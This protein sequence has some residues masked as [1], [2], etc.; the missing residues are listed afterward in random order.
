MF[1]L[2]TLALAVVTALAT[3][4]S[5]VFV[6]LRK[7]SMLVDGIG[8]AVFPGIVIG[9]LITRDLNSPLLLLGAALA[10]M[11]VVVGADWLRSTRMIS[12]DAP[13]GLIFP[14]LFAVG[15]IVV[16]SSLT[17]VHLDTHVV[18]VGDLNLASFDRLV[19]GG[20]D[21]G[22]SYLY[23][24]LTMLI[25]NAVFLAAALPRLTVSTFD[26]EFAHLIGVRTK[27]LGLVNM[28]LV[29]VTATA[30][31]HA[32]GA[33]LIIALMITPAATAHLVSKRV[34]HMIAWTLVFAGVGAIAGFL[35]AYGV[36]ASTSAGMAVYYGMQFA[37][38]LAW[39]HLR[40]RQAHRETPTRNEALL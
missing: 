15:V 26:P 21:V 33:L 4:L 28:F 1:I 16:S 5:G 36:D 31:F 27:R 11:L 38:V 17:D 35:I 14:A 22:P 6:V 10:G 34:G 9:Y 39:R 24:M 13:L 7:Q 20:V 23:V 8:H 25:I 12:G 32:A 2:G 40:D 30:A 3:A 19:L 18:L 29:S 37:L